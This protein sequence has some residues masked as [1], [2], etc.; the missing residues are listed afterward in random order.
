VLLEW[1]AYCDGRLPEL[2]APVWDA[3]FA[4]M[5]YIRPGCDWY[6]FNEIPSLPEALRSYA[7]GVAPFVLLTSHS[8]LCEVV[9]HAPAEPVFCELRLGTTLTARGIPVHTMPWLHGTCS[10]KPELIRRVP[11]PALYH[12]VKTLD[13]LGS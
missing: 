9:G 1:D 10:W 13:Q 6:W 4:A 11:R 5:D 2:L 3:P 12:P 8:A 7:A